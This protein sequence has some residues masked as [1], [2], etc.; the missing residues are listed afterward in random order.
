M[1]RVLFPLP[2]IE[3]WVYVYGMD[4]TTSGRQ[5]DTKLN[6]TTSTTTEKQKRKD[7]ADNLDD[8]RHRSSGN[9]SDNVTHTVT[10]LQLAAA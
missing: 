6:G 5:M 1:R 2:L 4:R 8:L 7:E 10:W 9:R 3:G